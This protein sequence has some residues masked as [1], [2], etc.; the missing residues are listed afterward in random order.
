MIVGKLELRHWEFIIAISV[1]AVVLLL[2]LIKFIA[3]S[4]HKERVVKYMKSIGYERYLIDRHV[5][6]GTD[7]W[8]Y[9]RE[10]SEYIEEDELFT[11]SLE[12]VKERFGGE[13]DA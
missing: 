5:I 7:M 11:M 4:I 3:V 10:G 13:G 8:M 2:L 6:T 1:C 9:A 12:E